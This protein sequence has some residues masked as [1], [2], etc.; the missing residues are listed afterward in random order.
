M[1]IIIKKASDIERYIKALVYGDPGIGKTTFAATGEGHPQLERTLFINIEGGM[2]SIAGTSAEATEQLRD[3]DSVE[4]VFWGLAQ[5]KEGWEHFQTVVIDSGT[6][7]Q[8]MDLEGIVAEARK[9]NKKRSLDDIYLEDYGK[10]TA[11]LK[12]VFRQ[13]RDLPMHVIVTCLTKRVMPPNAQKTNAQPRAI[14]P[15]L[16]EKLAM[17]L[18]GYMDF[19]WYMYIGEEGKRE[20]LTRDK[21]PYKAKTR[22]ARFS[23]ALGERV[24]EPNLATIYDLL[25]ETEGEQS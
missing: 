9:K 20:I 7:L 25:I 16:T 12:R 3:V 15:S 17:S 5:K 13:F 4:E 24:V 10:S 23:E 11:R 1:T 14:M 22:G 6:E 8:T 21:G 2:L 18:M 19:V